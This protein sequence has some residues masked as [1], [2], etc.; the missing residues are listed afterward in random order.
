M[1]KDFVFVLFSMQNNAL[2]LTFATVY[3]FATQK[4][5]F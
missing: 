3:I 4:T 5:H 2:E 1:G